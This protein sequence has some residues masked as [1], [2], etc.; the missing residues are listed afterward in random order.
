MKYIIIL[1][2]IITCFG[3]ELNADNSIPNIFKAIEKNSW[4][5]AEDIA[6]QN[7]DKYILKF[8]LSKKYLSN[9][10][11][12]YSFEEISHFIIQNPSWPYI[13]IF[14]RNAEK[15][16]DNNSD[17]RLVFAFLSKFPPLTSNGYKN[18]AYVAQHIVASQDHLSKIIK[19]AW[20][21]GSFSSK[22]QND[23]LKEFKKYIAYED[24]IKRAE[25]LLWEKRYKETEILMPLLKDDE[26]KLLNARIAL[27]K[28]ENNKFELF[29]NVPKQY[30]NNSGLLYDYCYLCRKED[31]VNDSAI[32]YI[33]NTPFDKLYANNWWKLKAYFVRELIREKQYDVAYKIAKNHNGFS[34]SDISEGEFLSGWLSLR[35][36]NRPAQAIEHFQN[37]NKVVKTPVSISRGNYWLARAYKKNGDNEL[38][39]K[40]FTKAGLYNYKY[41]GMLALD[42]LKI[43]QLDLPELETPKVEILNEVKKD[44][45][46]R[47]AKKLIKYDPVFAKDLSLS[48]I[49]SLKD[50]DRLV[51]IVH[52]LENPDT[53]Y[54][55]MEI[56]RKISE[57]SVFILKHLY[58]IPFEIKNSKVHPAHIYSVIKHESS[59]N[60]Y[61]VDP[62]N[63]ILGGLMQLIPETA[64]KV[65]DSI[66]VACDIKKLSDPDYNILLGSTHLNDLKNQYDNSLIHVTCA[67]NAGSHRVKKWIESF[68]NPAKM[69]DI[70]DIIDWIELIPFEVTRNYVQRMVENLQIYII[71]TSGNNKLVVRDLIMNGHH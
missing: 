3:F 67:Y 15:L 39:K 5:E 11:S 69:N 47:L 27:Q 18:F 26:K 65:A 53:T 12:Y 14:R 7:N 31:K 49:N 28:D 66:N 30:K 68:G 6:K 33:I 20:I 52:F 13:N 58:P 17:K 25:L 57:K 43:K 45:R 70:Y 21:H 38:A 62:A 22:E 29:N 44:G 59:F 55:N 34:P 41:Y 61:A 36:L 9:A 60:R 35:F 37:F 46:L 63:P 4:K 56:S 16:I 8:V 32:N 48:V 24:T 2:I 54:F 71:L 1:S 23:Y 51:A 50:F 40:Y 19:D 42:E 64:C 10:Y